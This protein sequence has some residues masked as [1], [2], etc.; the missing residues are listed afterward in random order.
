MVHGD[1]NGLRRAAAAR[2]D[3]GARH[4]GQG[5]RGRGGGG[6]QAARRRCRPPAYGSASTTGSTP[7][8]AAGPSTPSCKGYPGTGRGRPAR[9]GRRQRAWWPAGSTAPRRRSRWPTWSPTVT[10]ALE[11]DQQALYDE[12]LAFREARTVEVKTLGE[13]IEAAADR[14]GPG[15]VVG[16]RRGGRGGGERQGRHRALPDPRGR[17]GARLR[18]R[19]GPDRDPGPLLLIVTVRR[20]RAGPCCYRNVAA[21]AARLRSG[22]AG[23]SPTTSAGCCSGWPAARRWSTAGGRT[24]AACGTCRSPSGSALERTCVPAPLAGPGPAQV[25]PAGRRP[26]GLVLPRRRR[27]ASPLVRQP[28]GARRSAGTT[29]TWPGSTSIDQDLDIVVAPDRTWQWKDE[30]EFAERLAVP[31]H[32]WVPRRGGGPRRGS[33]GD[34]ADRGGRVP[35]R[36]HLDRLPARTR[37][38]RSRRRAARAGTGP[39]SAG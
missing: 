14:L 13:A 20:L 16:G 11:A 7:R 4:G 12:A 36:R 25:H 2:A 37:P 39:P 24:A 33:P 6:G 27:R 9:P 29:A 31:E 3:P 18:R 34:Q 19:A 35:V 5:R 30:D 22:R 26:L 38:G 28:G 17:L 32:Y 15:A 21:R 23:W 8:S 10:A 1:D